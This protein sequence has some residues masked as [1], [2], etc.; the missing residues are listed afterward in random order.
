MIRNRCVLVSKAV[1]FFVFLFQLKCDAAKGCSLTCANNPRAFSP[2]MKCDLLHGSYHPDLIN[3]RGEDGRTLLHNAIICGLGEDVIRFL[4]AH[5][6]RVDMRDEF[7]KMPLHYAAR[8][9]RPVEEFEL[10]LDYGAEVDAQDN[11]LK[12]PLDYVIEKKGA[13]SSGKKKDL[14]LRFA[15][16]QLRKRKYWEEEESE[17]SVVRSMKNMCLHDE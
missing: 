15:Y 17:K 11:L 12:T 14:L 3:S 9:I 13:P 1:F 2:M 7:G 16:E 4:L 6:A 8:H 5:G 10:L